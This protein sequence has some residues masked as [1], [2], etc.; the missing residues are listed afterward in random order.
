MELEEAIK[1]LKFMKWQY[2]K[3][4]QNTV[5]IT[6]FEEIGAIDTVLN[7]LDR[8]KNLDIYK[9]VEDYETGQLIPKEKILELARE[10]ED[11]QDKEDEELSNKGLDLGLRN[12]IPTKSKVA[13]KLR[14]FIK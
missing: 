5:P 4:P 3:T 10:L 9:L 13:D 1:K 7:E 14:K 8:L 6:Y 12:Y 2:Q 11:E